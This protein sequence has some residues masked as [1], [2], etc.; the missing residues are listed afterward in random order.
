MFVRDTP[1]PFARAVAGLISLVALVSLVFRVIDLMDRDG[2]DVLAAIWAMARFFTILTNAMICA[3]FAGI[4]LGL[5]RPS[6][7]WIASLTL[8]IVLVGT[9]YHFLLRGLVEL[10]PIGVLGDIGVHYLVPVLTVLWWLF[11][12]SKEGLDLSALWTIVALPLA[13]CAYAMTRAGIDGVFPYPFLDAAA[14]GWP[15]VLR[16]IAEFGGAVVLGGLL[17]IAISRVVTR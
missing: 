16:N 13:Y 12:G 7:A 9:V 11:Y 2:L 15:A 6:A 1:S 10:T 8:A 3:T 14:L 5:A 17:M 4:A